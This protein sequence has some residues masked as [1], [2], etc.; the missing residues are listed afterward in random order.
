M[1]LCEVR[2]VPKFFHRKSLHAICIAAFAAMFAI[3]IRNTA[4]A[5]AQQKLIRIGNSKAI[6]LRPEAPRA[7]IILMPGGDGYIGADENGTITRLRNNQLVRTREA[8]LNDNL[9]VL[10]IDADTNVAA[11][12]EYMAAIKRPVTI[13]ATSRGTLRVAH[14]IVRGAR[15]D[16]LVLTSGFLS[17]KSGSENVM[18]ILHSSESLPPTLI[19]HN[20]RDACHW[21]SPKGVEPF[22]RWS[23]GRA[24]VE[25]LDGGRNSGDPC[26][27]KAFHGFNGLDDKV[28]SLVISFHTQ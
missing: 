3:G 18:S 24:R 5:Q 9:A 28:V 4:L 8:Y 13:V 22:V 25:W 6:L 26:K 27:A 10:I 16:A 12:V 19:I 7:S 17:N 20:H 23:A 11:A 21:T 1:R 15:P 14:G 2:G